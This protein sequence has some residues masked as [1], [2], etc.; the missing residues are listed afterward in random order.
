MI[1]G[2]GAV[3][4]DKI[5][6][7]EDLERMVDT[8]DEWITARTGIK[9]RHIADDHVLNSD[10]SAEAARRALDDAGMSA[11]EIDII[12]MATVTGDMTF[13]ATAC[14]VQE[15]IGAVNAAAM[16]LSAAC[17][18]FIY[19]L[20]MADGLIAAGHCR[21]ALVIGCEMLSRIVDWSDRSTCVLFGDAAGA[22]VVTPANGEDGRGI[23]GTYIKS[24]GRLTHLLNMPGGG[25]KVPFKVAV[26]ENLCYL[27]M[28]GREV[29]KAAVNAMGEASVLVLEKAGLTSDQIDLF[30]PHQANIRIINATAKKL[31]F[32]DE[33]VYVNVQEYGNTSAASIPL[34]LDEARQKGLLNSGDTVLMVAFGGGL[35]WGSAIVRL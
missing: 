16:D 34:A 3:V 9:R 25:T 6:T 32:P 2:T 27:R 12:L 15:K 26:E 33:K 18:G 22:A 28:E 17:T 8:T 7:N 19:G 23:L 10:L 29:F 1:R 11:E 21:N 30:I 35:T 31:D 14:F 20:T 24:D 5:L 4:P 13:P